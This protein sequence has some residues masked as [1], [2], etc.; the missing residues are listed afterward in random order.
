MLCQLNEP[1]ALDIGEFVKQ[2]VAPRLRK[3]ATAERAV[4]NHP[5]ATALTSDVILVKL[6]IEFDRSG[7]V[8]RKLLQMT[9]LA[10]A[11]LSFDWAYARCG[12][13]ND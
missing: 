2:L 5:V 10:F 8:A 4:I 3:T 6:G 1:T 12:H 13:I 9:V 11:K 7:W